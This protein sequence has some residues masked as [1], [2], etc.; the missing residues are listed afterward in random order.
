[1]EIGCFE[2]RCVFPTRVGMDRR[3]LP[4]LP[5]PRCFPHT[6]GDGP[7]LQRC[8][9]FSN[10]FSPHAWGWTARGCLTRGG[11]CVFPT[12]V[13]MDRSHRTGSP[14]RSRFPH[15]RGDGPM[16]AD[17]YDLWQAFSPHAWGW[18]E[19][20][21]EIEENP[22][23][24]PTRVGMDRV[25]C[26]VSLYVTEF[27]PHAW[28]WTVRRNRRADGWPFSPHAWGWTEH[29]DA[30]GRLAGF[31]PHAWGW[32]V[33]GG[34]WSG[35]RHVFPTRVGMDRSLA[36]SVLTPVPFSPHAWGWTAIQ[37]LYT[38]HVSVFPTR[39]GM[40]RSALPLYM[41]AFT[42]SPHAWGWTVQRS[43]VQL[44]AGAFS[45]HAWGWTVW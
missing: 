13:G 19:L 7:C 9:R 12:R 38:A 45:P 17:K 43:A 16:G 30:V 36:A 25:G 41:D 23:V 42:F 29:G 1:M 5:V 32:T 20:A 14:R 11:G 35:G 4:R 8:N 3:S 15:T 22:F 18:T 31:S 24:F 39:V 6:R 34:T 37:T 44:V 21:G 2:G 26:P 27:S 10:S 40:D 28:G 33:H